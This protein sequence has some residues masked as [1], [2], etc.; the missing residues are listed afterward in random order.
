ME[1]YYGEVIHKILTTDHAIYL[2]LREAMD[3]GVWFYL[4][5]FFF[6]IKISSNQLR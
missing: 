1:D 6:A 2:F 3:I 4:F 5:G